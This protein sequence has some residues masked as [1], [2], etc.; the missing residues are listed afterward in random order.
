MENAAIEPGSRS[1][2]PNIDQISTSVSEK[3]LEVFA[4]LREVLK[5]HNMLERFGVMLLHRHFDIEPSEILMETIDPINRVLKIQPIEKAALP[6]HVQTSWR[7]FD[8]GEEAIQIQACVG[9]VTT[10]AYA[11]EQHVATHVHGAN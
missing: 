8:N 1:D 4:E 7:F 10:C 2:I 3:D 11:G 9:C 6:E 5:R